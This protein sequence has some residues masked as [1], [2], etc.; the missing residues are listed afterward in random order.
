M[1]GCP[2]PILRQRVPVFRAVRPACRILNRQDRGGP[3]SACPPRRHIWRTFAAKRAP[4]PGFTE[5][6][7]DGRKNPARRP[8]CNDEQFPFFF[9]LGLQL[10]PLILESRFG[11]RPSSCLGGSRSSRLLR[12]VGAARSVGVGVGASSSPPQAPRTSVR[13]AASMTIRPMPRM[14]QAVFM[15]ILPHDRLGRIFE[16]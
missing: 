16:C 1:Q 10:C 5:V 15:R 7:E 4:V 2:V 13:T 8:A 11:G 6:L 12:G 9:G 14:R 3:L